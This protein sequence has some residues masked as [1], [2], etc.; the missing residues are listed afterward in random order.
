MNSEKFT[1]LIEVKSM[2]DKLYMVELIYTRCAWD[3][4]IVRKKGDESKILAF[5]SVL[6]NLYDHLSEDLRLSE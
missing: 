5:R 4:G 1:M 2:L 6:E 3:K